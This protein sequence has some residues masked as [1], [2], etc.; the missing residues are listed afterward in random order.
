MPFLEIGDS[1]TKCTNRSLPQPVAG[2]G[3]G[4][5]SGSGA[6]PLAQVPAHDP[7]QVQAPGAGPWSGPGTGTVAGAGL[8]PKADYQQ[9]ASTGNQPHL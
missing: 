7:A 6:G 1:V 3:A 4:P 5:W 2:P 9:F 8:A